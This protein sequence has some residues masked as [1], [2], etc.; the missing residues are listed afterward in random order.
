MYQNGDRIDAKALI[1]AVRALAAERPD[2]VY[3]ADIGSSGPSCYYTT[4]DGTPDCIIGCAMARIGQALPA[5]LRQG[6]NDCVLLNFG[7]ADPAWRRALDG[8]ENE[9]RWLTAV[10]G[11]QDI[12]HHW[13]EAVAK[14]DR[15]Y[16]I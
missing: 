8:T 11:S 14:A 15:D 12:G 3:V 4:E 10:Q 5:Q 2:F 6:V 9:F 7:V 1:Q 13:S 16:T